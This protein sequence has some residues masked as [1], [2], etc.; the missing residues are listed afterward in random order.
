[1]SVASATTAAEELSARA[2]AYDLDTEDVAARL[3]RSSAG[4]VLAWAIDRFHPRLYIAASFQK[5][6]SVIAHMA[7][8]IEPNTRFF[9]LDTDLLFPETYETRDRLADRLGIEFQRYRGITLAEQTERYGDELWKTDP[10]TCCGLR[11]VEPMRMALS[12]VDCWV[13]G[14]RRADGVSRANA[15]KF[16]Y[17]RRFD[18]WKVN[19]LADWS[20]QDIWNYIR[21]H[22]L[23]YNPLH[24][25]GYPSIGCVPCTT[26]VEPGSELR[27]GR[28]AGTTKRECGLN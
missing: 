7:T 25:R 5:T 26:P 13:S 15:P 21:E 2:A 27:A 22:D 4:E 20:E 19:P 6:S 24:D 9:Y 12:S 17:D 10:D 18:L 14:I 1:M 3:E 8:E 11:K 28:W 16:L 23:P